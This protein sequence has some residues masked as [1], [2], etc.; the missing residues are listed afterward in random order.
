MIY[1]DASVLVAAVVDIEPYHAP[2]ARLLL[3]K[4]PKAVRSHGLV[5]TFSTLTGGRLPLRLSPSVADRL[6]GV[7]LVPRLRIVDLAASDV[8]RAIADSESRGVRGGAI[9]DLLHLF[10]AKKAKASTLYTLN[11]SHFRAFHR[12]GDPEVRL[13]E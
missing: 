10:A 5:E 11:L 3:S 4:E 12:R 6:I 8:M 7:N 9:H 1:L 2:C 13:P